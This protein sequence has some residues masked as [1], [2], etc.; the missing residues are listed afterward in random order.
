MKQELEIKSQLKITRIHK[1]YT[2]TI[3]EEE[4]KNW[5]I[6]D[7]Q[8]SPKAPIYTN[9]NFLITKIAEI[10]IKI[11]TFLIIPIFQF[12]AVEK[13]KAGSWE[14]RR[15]QLGFFPGLG[16]SLFSPLFPLLLLFWPNQWDFHHNIISYKNQIINK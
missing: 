2:N 16:S 7:H 4:K 14:A 10:K 3:R 9:A 6:D 15:L 13:R 5:W 11:S 12:V 1:N 8:E